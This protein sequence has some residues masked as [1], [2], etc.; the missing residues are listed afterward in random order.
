MADAIGQPMAIRIDV[1]SAGTKTRITIAGELLAE[2]VGELKKASGTNAD[3][4]ELDLSNLTFADSEGVAAL[5]R[6]IDDGAIA[7]GASPFIRNLLSI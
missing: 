6:L 7:T 2:R 3:S 4:L 5:R 1:E